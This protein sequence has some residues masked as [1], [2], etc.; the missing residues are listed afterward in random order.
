MEVGDALVNQFH[1]R[2]DDSINRIFSIFDY[3]VN[4]SRYCQSLVF[5][6]NRPNN[7]PSIHFLLFLS[8]QGHQTTI[9]FTSTPLELPVH[10]QFSSRN[11]V[12]TP[13]LINCLLRITEPKRWKKSNNSRRKKKK[14]SI[15]A[16]RGFP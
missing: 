12:E 7:S 5:G 8:L 4:Y 13:S 15:L 14:H 3:G 9:T 2:S 6:L 10:R 11:W 16:T 1:N